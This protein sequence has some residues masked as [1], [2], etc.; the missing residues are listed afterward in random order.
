MSLAE[1]RESERGETAAVYAGLRAGVGVR[2]GQP[3]LA[4]RRRAGG[5][6]LAVGAGAAGAGSGAAAGARDP[7]AA[8]VTLPETARWM[9]LP[10]SRRWSGP[11]IAAT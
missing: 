10:R 2:A 7:I 8:A 5:A 11:M 1:I 4:H 9:R 6:G 3:D